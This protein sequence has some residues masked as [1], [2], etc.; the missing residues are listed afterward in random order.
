MKRTIKKI[1]L[2]LLFCLGIMLILINPIQNY[3]I[4]QTSQ[5][6][7]TVEIAEDSPSI[8][9]T[10]DFKA[11]QSL[12]IQ[13]VLKAQLKREEFLV[14]GSITIPE[15]QLSLPIGKG[16]SESILAVGAGTMKPD[17]KPGEGNYALASHYIEGEGILF[18]P[19]YNVQ[20]GDKVYISDK[21][22]MYEYQITN[23]QIILDTDV[24]VI[25]DTPN[26]KLLTL[27]TCAEQGTKRLLVQ[28]EFIKKTPLDSST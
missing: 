22:D 3:F 13:D 7:L 23:K 1:S 8:E 27:I 24:E 10:F 11:V 5:R 9:A 14:I 15:V 28:G 12:A 4:K 17:Q 2:I 19:L 25:Y 26:Q 21:T 20:I 6:L 16:V 18:G